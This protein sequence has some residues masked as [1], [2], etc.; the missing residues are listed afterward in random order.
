MQSAWPSPPETGRLPVS[1]RRVVWTA[2]LV[3][4]LMCAFASQASAKTKWLCKPGM[5]NDPCVGSLDTTY[6]STTG[7]LLPQPAVKILNEK[8]VDCFYVYPT[9]S[10]Q[11]GPNAN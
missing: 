6:F 4:A 11:Q 10:D 5:S 8:R 7:Q 1:V 9:V 2:A 3:L